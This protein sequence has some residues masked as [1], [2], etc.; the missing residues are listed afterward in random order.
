[1][2][3]SLET[4]AN[5]IKGLNERQSKLSELFQKINNNKIDNENDNKEELAIIEKYQ[6][7]YPELLGDNISMKANSLLAIKVKEE[8]EL[9]KSET[10]IKKIL[11]EITSLKTRQNSLHEQITHLQTELEEKKQDCDQLNNQYENI[12]KDISQVGYTIKSIQTLLL[13]SNENL[14]KNKEKYM[15][16]KNEYDQINNKQNQILND[17]EEKKHQIEDSKTIYAQLEVH[18]KNIE[19]E[20]ESSRQKKDLKIEEISCGKQAVLQLQIDIQNQ[21]KIVESLE[22]QKKTL[23]QEYEELLLKEKEAKNSIMEK[24]QQILKEKCVSALK[25]M[26]KKE[27]AID[28]DEYIESSQIPIVKNS[29]ENNMNTIDHNNNDNDQHDNNDMNEYNNDNNQYNNDN[30][31][32][33]Q[34]SS[35]NMISSRDIQEKQ[36]KIDVIQRESSSPPL[37]SSQ[38]NKS[39]T[40]SQSIVLLSTSVTLDIENKNSIHNKKRPREDIEYDSYHKSINIDNEEKKK[41]KKTM[42]IDYE[43]S[44]L[45]EK[46]NTNIKKESPKG[47][48]EYI[49]SLEVEDSEYS[50]K[51]IFDD[52]ND[53]W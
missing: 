37:Y 42:D 44:I 19:K 38:S 6:H 30:N 21:T 39:D 35:S 7:E 46:E 26:D 36:E 33:S 3:Q 5:F 15:N 4:L 48:I 1:M 8:L 41:K 20:I 18:L 23:S 52:F 51:T 16:L 12:N 11:C 14:I 31:I 32:S 22:C 28:K 34:K 47:F 13:A 53:F 27:V 24:E 10:V 50:H 29:N 49:H 2:I 9:K 45:L 43:D 25:S 40:L 17:I